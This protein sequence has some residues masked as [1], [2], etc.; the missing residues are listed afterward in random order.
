LLPLWYD[1]PAAHLRRL[2]AN[3]FDARTLRVFSAAWL[4]FGL[5]IALVGHRVGE[6]MREYRAAAHQ[7]AT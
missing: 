4:F 2:G 7:A 6:R 3:T 5:L 1:S